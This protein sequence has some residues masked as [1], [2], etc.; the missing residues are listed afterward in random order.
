MTAT[1]TRESLGKMSG[2]GLRRCFLLCRLALS[3]AVSF[4]LYDLSLVS[5]R[6]GLYIIRSDFENCSRSNLI[7]G[8]KLVC[9]SACPDLLFRALDRPGRTSTK[10][11]RRNCSSNPVPGLRSFAEASDRVISCKVHRANVETPRLHVSYT[12][13]RDLMRTVSF[14]Q[15]F[16]MLDAGESKEMRDHLEHGVEL[17]Y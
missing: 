7:I 11:S 6:A 3:Y 16:L 13:E 4:A 9:I 2:T 14:D 15:Q 5:S 1:T 12:T 8:R 10:H 17:L